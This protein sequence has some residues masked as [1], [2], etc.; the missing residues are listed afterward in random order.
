MSK[1]DQP[2]DDARIVV[3]L[4]NID[5]KGGTTD[6]KGV[7]TSTHVPGERVTDIGFHKGT[8][9]MEALRMITDEQGIWQAQ[10]WA[11]PAWVESTH[12]GLAAVL[13]EQYG[14]PVGRPKG[15]GAAAEIEESNDE[16]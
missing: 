5:A 1:T 9:V 7:L 8:S 3:H 6:A 16:D 15:W 14:C 12:P 4:G 11:P 10:S 2:G 13:A